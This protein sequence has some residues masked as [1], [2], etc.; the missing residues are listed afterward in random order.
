MN[1]CVVGHLIG[2]WN[3][4]DR[5]RGKGYVIKH[6]PTCEVIDGYVTHGIR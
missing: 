5:L 2:E 1:F 4:I 6:I 3:V